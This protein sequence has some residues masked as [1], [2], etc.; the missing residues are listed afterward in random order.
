MGT[1]SRDTFNSLKQYVG[2][3]LQQGV[4][5]VDADWNELEDIR[6]FEL[7]AFLKWYVGDGI[8]Q[9]NNGFAIQSIPGVDND[10]MIR[11]GDGT[12]TGA[13]RCL[14]EGM[15]VLNANDIR[16]SEQVLV[17]ATKAV[18]MGVSPVDLLTA[19]SVD[20][21]YYVYLDVWEREVLPGEPG[22]DPDIFD[23]NLINSEIGV[24]TCTRIKREW[25]VRIHEVDE[26][27]SP[28]TCPAGHYFYPLARINRYAGQARIYTEDI[29]DLRR[30]GLT[31][32]SYNDTQQIV[33]DA[34]GDSYTLDGNGEA[35]LSVSLRDTINALLRNTIPMT[36][37]TQFTL[38][39]ALE[40]EASA[41]YDHNGNLWVFWSSARQGKLGI[42]YKRYDKETK[43]W[44]PET[45]LTDNTSGGL[46]PEVIVDSNNGI[47]V[48]WCSFRNN[49]LHIVCDHRQPDGNWS[50][51][52]QVSSNATG[53]KPNCISVAVD[54]L[55]Q[56]WVFW[57]SGFD[58]NRSI[59][60]NCH[61]SG[62]A[63]QGEQQLATSTAGNDRDPSAVV[64]A[65]GVVCVCWESMRPDGYGYSIFWNWYDPGTGWN[66]SHRSLTQTTHSSK[67]HH[68]NAVLTPDGDIWI[69]HHARIGY[70]DTYDI[71]CKRGRKYVDSGGITSWIWGP[72]QQLTT[73]ASN[74]KF[75]YAV[76]D[77]RGDIWMF[78]I[79]DRSGEWS[80]WFKHYSIESGWSRSRPITVESDIVDIRSSIRA[81][82]ICAVA[83]ENMIQIFWDRILETFPTA[84][85]FPTTSMLV[86]SEIWHTS[87]VSKI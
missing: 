68:P 56:I 64:D 72:E 81:D 44:S 80:Y 48:F 79:S 23:I 47:W 62:G 15:D 2:V 85:P 71:W 37:P 77:N 60:Y 13:G 45:Q 34:F 83:D 16:Y 61:S 19:A 41:V 22:D 84:S 4:P 10:F 43:T 76:V 49:E 29:T 25:V 39:S 52:Q 50:G 74:N 66:T 63:W 86:S 30:T 5:L 59:N 31:V 73:N 11:G 24:E 78:W 69:F 32:Q 6:R 26:L 46:F 18:A 28:P 75:A 35:N 3:R 82:G 40:G 42:W 17:D 87:L 51:E 38:A 67:E 14:V 36:T 1:I 33:R 27:D 70:P 12:A 9:G 55:G 20:T 21:D 54:G 7:R 53:A 57:D 8:P 58:H 65:D